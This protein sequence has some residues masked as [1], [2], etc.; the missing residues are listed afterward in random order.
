MGVGS[1]NPDLLLSQASFGRESKSGASSFRTAGITVS[2]SASIGSVTKRKT[3][4]RATSLRHI[5]ADPDHPMPDKTTLQSY[6]ARIISA[7][8]DEIFAAPQSS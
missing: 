2:Y 8:G 1:I 7:I 5:R 6:T 3:W 4:R